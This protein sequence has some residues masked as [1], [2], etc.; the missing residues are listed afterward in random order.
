MGK[1]A[2]GLICVLI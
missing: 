2:Y 1:D